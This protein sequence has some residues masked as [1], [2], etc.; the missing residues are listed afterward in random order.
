MHFPYLLG[1]TTEYGKRIR[2]ARKH[3]KMTQAQLAEAIGASQSNLSDMEGKATGSRF[4]PMV[5]AVCKVSATWLATGEGDML[6]G[7]ALPVEMEGN[8]D[9]PAIRRVKFKL[10]AGASGF[11][12]EYLDDEG[13]PIVF[14]RQW[15]EQRG[16]VP[17]KLFA[18]KVSGE[19]MET[20]M[21]D[22][23]TV[24]VNTNQTTPIDGVVFAINYE[25]ELVIKRLVRDA[26]RWWLSSDN[27]D[28]L[29]YPRKICHE[30]CIIL[31]EIVHKQS[32]K[33]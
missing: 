11:G 18:V 33:I 15:Y 1:M 16:F 4:T 21:H 14:G 27:P 2:A 29:R 8:P 3:A 31:G 23:D 20:G 7:A 32:E 24:V 25:G 12:I 5:A 30:D 22:G 28:Q 17:E 13:I 26:G 9:R 6:G 10:S 19:S